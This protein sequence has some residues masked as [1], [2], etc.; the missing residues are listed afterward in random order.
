MSNDTLYIKVDKDIL[1]K[2][3]Q[4]LLQDVAKL[5]CTN[6]AALRQLKQKKIYTFS[7]K[8][9][10]NKKEKQS[11]VFSILKIVELIHEDYPNL[12]ISNQG[13][14][15]FIV[16]YEPG[17]ECVWL[18]Y[19][20]AGILAVIIF[21]GAAFTIMAFN[22]DI[23]I[24]DVFEKFYV[25]VMGEKPQGITVLEISYCIGL[26]LGITVFFNHF[27]KKKIT[28]DPTPIQVQMRKYADDIDKVFIENAERKG[29]NID[30]D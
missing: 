18:E 23:G 21:F 15:D 24:T 14:K 20:K 30:V 6:Q 4:V 28:M 12:N 8:D 13:E 1:L 9:A 5:E 7:D 17:E 27:G 11:V 29:H 10:Q 25:Q 22:N 2:K 3:R 16:E 26:A 19:T